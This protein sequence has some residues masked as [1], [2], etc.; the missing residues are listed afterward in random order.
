MHKSFATTQFQQ[1]LREDNV[2]ADVL[3]NMASADEIMN[4]QIKVQY[5][6]SID[7]LDVHQI[8]EVAN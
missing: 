1:I 3:A 5:I 6:M 4:D 7:I 8:H 2:E